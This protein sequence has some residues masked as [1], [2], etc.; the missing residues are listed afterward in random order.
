MGK[1]DIDW[2]L[3]ALGSAHAFILAGSLSGNL[4]VLGVVAFR[5]EMRSVTNILIAS[6]A[7]S[8]MLLST[9][10]WMTPLYHVLGRWPFG[11]VLCHL[12][13]VVLVLF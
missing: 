11:G 9:V 12:H 6:S 3:V 5:K 13:Q 8:D 7:S 2:G 4:G 1:E 10:F